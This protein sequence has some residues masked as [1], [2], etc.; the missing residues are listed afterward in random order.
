MDVEDTAARVNRFVLRAGLR[1]ADA[2]VVGD[3][4]EPGDVGVEGAGGDRWRG[5]RGDQF[6]G[7]KT[8]GRLGSVLVAG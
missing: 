6:T 5:D 1:F 4:Y 2:D 7:G 3:E 8:C